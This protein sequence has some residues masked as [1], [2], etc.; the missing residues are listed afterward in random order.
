MKN[1]EEELKKNKLLRHKNNVGKKM[2]N[3]IW[4]H[5]NYILDYLKKEN[6]E[7]F[8]N[9]L[10]KKFDFDIVK[11]TNEREMS[12]I[13][14][15]NFNKEE[16]PTINLVLKIKFENNEYTKK[17]INK[18]NDPLIYHH[19]WMFVKDDYEGFNVLESKERSL[20]WKT[21]LG[22]NRE[23]SNKIGRKSFWLNWLMENNI[24]NNNEKKEEN[25]IQEFIKNKKEKEIKEDIWGIYIN[26]KV[27]QS[28][29]SAA[30]ARLQ[31]PKTFKIIDQN[32]LFK[33]SKILLDIGCGSKNTKFKESIENKNIEYHGIDPFNK[34]Y[35][36]N[37][38]SIE[39]CMNGN[40]DIV[41]LNNV[42]NTIPEKEVWISILEQ[43]K[44][45][46]H[47]KNGIAVILTY[48]GEKTQEEKRN[49]IESGYKL[50]SLKPIKTRDGWQNRMKTEEYLDTIKEVFPNVEIINQNGSKVILATKNEKLDL[51]NKNIKKNKLK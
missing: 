51:K 20:L 13:K 5:K 39:K 47:E 10:P 22:I 26:N 19:K 2:G 42:L 50:N 29:T 3:D 1:V 18:P 11:I 31:I 49:E 44:N 35:E 40:A 28:V 17:I 12:F 45:A 48:E 32:N 30:T 21:K 23:V 33:E 25:T 24:M 27:E 37:I 15:E 43:A 36:S 34:S 14:C 9:E 8:R 4:V 38:K 6:Y 16:E 7:M 46:L 41:T